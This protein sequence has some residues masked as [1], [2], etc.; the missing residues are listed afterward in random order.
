M[1]PKDQEVRKMYSLTCVPHS[2]CVGSFGPYQA[3]ELSEKG[4]LIG[5]GSVTLQVTKAVSL[6]SEPCKVNLPF[7]INI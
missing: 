6:H 3:T 2:Q 1:A 5:S 4:N 7:L